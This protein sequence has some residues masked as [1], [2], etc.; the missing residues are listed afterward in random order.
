MNS[1]CHEVGVPYGQ[2]I[3]RGFRGR[4]HRWWHRS[5]R[6]RRKVVSVDV[7]LW[8]TLHNPRH[9]HVACCSHLLQPQV[10]RVLTPTLSP[11][12]SP[13]PSLPHSTE[14]DTTA[15]ATAE[16]AIGNLVKLSLTTDC[17]RLVAA[18][19]Q[20]CVIPLLRNFLAN[21]LVPWKAVPAPSLRASPRL[22]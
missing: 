13:P 10:S 22:T 17:H 1:R 16:K 14:A 3:I 19:R 7:R 21:K 8:P 11:P 2:M 6:W 5:W 12:P 18:H 4:Y 9:L 15:S 20:H